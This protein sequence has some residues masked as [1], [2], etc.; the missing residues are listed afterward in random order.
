MNPTDM[1]PADGARPLDDDQRFDLLVDGELSEPQRHEL[2][3]G[4]DDE[5]GGWRRCA[6]AFLEAQAWKRDL[7]AALHEPAK[8]ST[9]S[10]PLQRSRSIGY[11]GTLLAVAASFVVA[12]FLGSW[13]RSAWHAPAP[14]PPSSH[15]PAEFAR[16]TGQPQGPAVPPDRQQT[17]V[18]DASPEPEAP[19]GKV[20]MVE[21]ADAE[22]DSEPI[23]VPAV[24][25]DRINDEWLQ[26]FPAAIPPEIVDVWRRHGHRVRQRR[27]LLP[28]RL[29]DGRQLIVPV[30]E[31]DIHYVGRPAL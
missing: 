5:P 9:G 3:G 14:S 24:E 11:G 23:R 12:L 28:F 20:W 22:G 30:D 31:V 13:L 25:R 7:G 4:L 19:A 6:L 8:P 17:M 15:S 27:Q 2:L 18:A 1:N 21:L 10:R 26:S 16:D 29:Q